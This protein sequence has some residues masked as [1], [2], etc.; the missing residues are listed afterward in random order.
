M[1]G[2]FDNKMC[3]YLGS[4]GEILGSIVGD[5]LQLF[6]F[7]NLAEKKTNPYSISQN[8]AGMDWTIETAGSI[9][10]C[11]IR[12]KKINSKRRRCEEKFVNN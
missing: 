11:V 10:N 8:W 6:V 4:M 9:S 3:T 12:K 1:K 2:T 7:F 5:D